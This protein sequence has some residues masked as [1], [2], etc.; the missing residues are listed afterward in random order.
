M[1]LKD[2]RQQAVNLFLDIESGLCSSNCAS[3]AYTEK[4][5]CDCVCRGNNHGLFW[6]ILGIDLVK[7]AKEVE[8]EAA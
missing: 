8:K 7:L 3:A 4:H 5:E 2:A 6:R 1:N